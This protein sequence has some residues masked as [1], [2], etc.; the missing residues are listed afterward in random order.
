MVGAVGDVKHRFILRTHWLTRRATVCVLPRPGREAPSRRVRPG[1]PRRTTST[2]ASKERPAPR[3]ATMNA[4]A[5]GR[6]RCC[7]AAAG[8]REHARVPYVDE[9]T[10]VQAPERTRPVLP[11]GPACVEGITHNYVRRG[12]TTHFAAPDMANGSVPTQ[13]RPR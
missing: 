6:P 1:P 3:R 13:C 5:P 8:S 10:Q 9:K 12:T 11:P 2:N 4:G 7:A